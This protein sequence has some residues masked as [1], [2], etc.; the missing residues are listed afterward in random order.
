MEDAS[1]ELRVS[2]TSKICQHMRHLLTRNLQRRRDRGK[3]A[4]RAFRKRQADKAT[5]QR[6]NHERLERLVHEIVVA[7]G[8][9]DRAQLDRAVAEAGALLGISP[10]QSKASSPAR[11]VA[12]DTQIISSVNDAVSSHPSLEAGNS[13]TGRFSPRLD[14][15]LLWLEPDRFMKI[16]DPPSD[17]RPYIGTG[18][19]TVAG[20]VMWACLDHGLAVL[21]QSITDAAFGDE[22]VRH[23][24]PS[25]QQLF[26][27]ALGHMEPLPD[28]E[29]VMAM[30]EA[31]H[32]FRE[33]GYMRS[34]NSGADEDRR[35]ALENTV[36]RSLR[37]KGIKFDLWWTALDISEYSR[38]SMGLSK[39]SRFQNGLLDRRP[40]E[41]EAMQLLAQR[42]APRAVCFGNGPR[43][44]AVI[45]MSFVD[46]WVRAGA[47]FFAQ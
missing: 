13:Q 20:H 5:E 22:A 39:F 15:G 27:F 36:L 12:D 31:R 30:L 1:H 33:M 45:V 21:R 26:S 44:N 25:A 34:D 38:M 8:R 18:K 29:Y 3:V 14:Y 37:S 46:S 43:W 9:E 28:V 10:P 35:L 17:I 2:R 6:R 24:S 40:T 19:D 23:L 32:E 47:E 4:Q 7:H 41:V 42:L 16:F 11:E